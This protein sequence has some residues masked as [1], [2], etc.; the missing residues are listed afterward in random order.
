[1]KSFRV[2]IAIS[3]FLS[4]GAATVAVHARPAGP[5][6]QVSGAVVDSQF[7]GHP[8]AVKSL[9]A[10][11][12]DQQT[13]AT[14]FGK[15]TDAVRPIASITKL[16]TAM[17]VLDARQPMQES[18]AIEDEDVDTLKGTHSRLRVGTRL[19]REELMRL[20]LMSSENRAAAALS[21]AYPGGTEAMIA[22]MNRKAADLGM[23][24][25]HFLDPTGLTS[26]N[27]STASDLV[28]MVDAGYRYPAIR[29]Y[30]TTMRYDVLINGREQTFR[31]TNKLVQNGTWDIGLS[32]TGFINEA[33]RC[34]VMQAKLAEKN[35]LIVLL[36]S[37]GKY[38][39]IGD[40]N[41]IRKWLESGL[42]KPRVSS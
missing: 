7:P 33:G 1:M 11:V 28:K 23:R 10:L 24:D 36:D 29:E 40:A 13:G 21:R 41:R 20:A 39:R 37:W 8:P 26:A 22:A 30:T 9:A 6:N 42:L 18:I 31:N 5:G 35:V 27:V 2:L 4:S 32:K 15:N 17:V 16:M 12:F 34:L 38:T 19:T 25:S 14:M 3:L